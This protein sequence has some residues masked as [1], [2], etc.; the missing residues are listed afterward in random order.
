MLEL[1]GVAKSFGAKKVLTDITLEAKEGKTTV[2]FGLSG[3][4]KSTIIKLIV[5]LLEP[6]GGDILLHN[7][8]ILSAS[9][10]RLYE[11]RKEIG[12]LFQSGALFDSKN[13]YENV[14]FPLREHTRLSEREI[15]AK[16]LSRLEMVG[17]KPDEV[18]LL[19]PDELSGG[20]KKRVGLARSIILDPKVILYDEPTSGLDPITSDL[21]T[22]MIIHLQKELRTTSIL[23]SH[24]LKESF[25]AA[26][27]MAM[28]FEGRIIECS[29][30]EQFAK[31]ENPRVRQ[32]L[33]GSS[34]GPINLN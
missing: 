6:D 10:K 28:L 9:P 19:Y 7:E 14:A 21:I 3:S 29:S 20:M 27:Y 13:V 12:F 2:I 31:S 32:F 25:K 24:D 26:D 15:R 5:R 23:I 1:K 33:E 8:S 18:A 11:L 17:L 22:Q 16:V 30:K 34:A 4:G